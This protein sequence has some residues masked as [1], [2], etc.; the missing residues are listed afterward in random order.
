MFFGG[1]F[2]GTRDTRGEFFLVPKEGQRTRRGKTLPL[3][4]EEKGATRR[5]SGREF[6]RI[7]I[8][9][10]RVAAVSILRGSAPVNGLHPPS[11]FLAIE[12]EDSVWLPEDHHQFTTDRLKL[13]RERE[14]VRKCKGI[15][16]NSPRM[17]LGQMSPIPGHRSP[18]RYL[19]QNLKYH[20]H[21]NNFR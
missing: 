15:T 11:L 19:L 20:I 6:V 12:V 10:E 5:R 18:Y 16:E 1:Y 13:S 14:R 9:I 21:L 7:W 2:G 3:A 8:E 17:C 4:K